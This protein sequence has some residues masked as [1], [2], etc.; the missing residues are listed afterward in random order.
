MINIIKSL[1]NQPMARP[2]IVKENKRNKPLD[3]GGFSITVL[4]SETDT[5]DYEIFHL[6]GPEGKGPGPHFH[7]WDESFFVINGELHCGID[8]EETV[9]LP[10]TLVHVPAGSTHWFRFGKGGA[11]LVAITS[12][13]NASK[14]F[15]DF[16][17][18]VSWDSPDREKLIEL[19]AKYGQTILNP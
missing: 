13:G 1:R 9:A 15:T 11:T 4:A 17:Q 7:P 5:G 19:A 10:G 14:M 16:A 3:V 6:S 18:G 12:R 8:N 2:L